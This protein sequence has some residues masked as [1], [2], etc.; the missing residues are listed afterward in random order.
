MGRGGDL[1]QGQYADPWKFGVVSFL[2]ILGWKGIWERKREAEPLEKLKSLLDDIKLATAIIH[3]KYLKNTFMK[4]QKI[5]N[6]SDTIAIFS[7]IDMGSRIEKDFDTEL[8]RIAWDTWWDKTRDKTLDG[9]KI[10]L[11]LLTHAVILSSSISSSIKLHIPVRGV[12]C[13]GNYILDENQFLGPAID[14]AAEWFDKCDWIGVNLTPSALF[15]INGEIFNDSNA[16]GTWVQYPVPSKKGP[17][18]ESFCVNWPFFWYPN[19]SLPQRRKL[20]KQAFKDMGPIGPDIV[21]K[22]TNTLKFFDQFAQDEVP[23]K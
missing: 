6:I 18:W 14:E 11:T 16:R 4:E 22:F 3:E 9:T 15:S 19:E 10:D 5:L 8:K 17:K 13:V 20:L 7:E 21:G 23:T 12:T 1:V 2:D